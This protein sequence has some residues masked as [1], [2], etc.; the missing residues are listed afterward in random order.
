[1]KKYIKYGVAFA[2]VAVIVAVAL[3]GQ[4]VPVE[5]IEPQRMTV[6]QYIAE[7]AKTRLRDRYIIDMPVAGTLDRIQL[8]VGD[9]VEEGECVARID[10]YDLEKDIVQMRALIAQERARVTGVDVAKPKDEDLA[11]AE[12]HI[13]EMRDALEIARQARTRLGVQYQEAQRAYE[14]AKSLLAAGATSEA[15]LDEAETRYKSLAEDI[16][17]A[18]SEK[19]SAQKALEQAEIAYKR[20]VDSVD[21]NEFERTMHLAEIDRLEAQLSRLQNDLNKTNICSPV[22]GPVLEKYVEDSRVL[23]AGVPL[24]EIGDMNSIEIESDILSEEIPQVRVGNFVELRGKALDREEAIGRV[25]RIYP[26]GFEKISAL[27]VEQQ[28]VK[29]IVAFDNEKLQLRP[30]TSIDVRIVTAESENTLAVPDR[31]VFRNEDGWAL[32]VAED[33]HARLRT[34]EVGLR[35]DEWVE[36]LSGVAEEDRVIAE[37]SNTLSDGAKVQVGE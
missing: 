4:P 13:Q 17:S 21:D 33:G 25:K 9:Y 34:I 28:R 7:D 35:N 1:M 36:V 32:F 15:A 10:P 26:S 30:G 12:L 8:E 2:L 37:L 31:A 11:S 5:A 27:G 23:A 24:L 22:A 3:R 6:R 16:K 29:V 18:E 19:A 14:R 20:V